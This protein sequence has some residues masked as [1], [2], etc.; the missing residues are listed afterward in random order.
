M[1]TLRHYRL[2]LGWFMTCLMA[3]WLPGPAARGATLLWDGGSNNWDQSSSF[4]NGGGV[5]T[6]SADNI[7][8]F[9]G[10]SGTV[11]LAEAI[12]A[13]GLILNTTGY[14]V[15]GNTL[16]LSAPAGASSPSVYVRDFTNATVSSLIA[17]TD[18]LTKTGNGTLFLT[19]N[20]NTYT[21]DTVINAGGSG[22]HEPDSAR[23]F[24][25][26]HLRQRHRWHRESWLHG[27]PVRGQRCLFYRAGHH[28][29]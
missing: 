10:T 21:G 11:S 9:G 1:K 24:L 27:R 2:Q 17:G 22:D 18:G 12:L 3:L 8:Q 4:W 26:C 19:N 25:D 13:G 6:N 23:S 14:V 29:S 7:A 15:T 28:D 5:W 20:A 16:T